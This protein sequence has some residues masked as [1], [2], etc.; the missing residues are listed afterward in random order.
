MYCSNISIDTVEIASM[1]NFFIWALILCK[2]I[3][4][5]D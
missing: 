3:I 5:G 2:S 4:D 1:L